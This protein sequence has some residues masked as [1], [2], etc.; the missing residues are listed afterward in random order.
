MWWWYQWSWW[1]SQV[2]PN[3]A[4]CYHNFSYLCSSLRLS[5]ES[6]PDYYRH[7]DNRDDHHADSDR[8]RHN[9]ADDDRRGDYL[10]VSGGGCS[11]NEGALGREGAGEVIGFDSPRDPFAPFSLPEDPVSSKRLSVRSQVGCLALPWQST[12]HL[13]QI[14]SPST[15]AC[16][17]NAANLISFYKGIKLCCSPVNSCSDKITTWWGTCTH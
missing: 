2:G 15:S 17:L 8:D 9:Y 5:L 12:P 16:S 10:G 7:Y 4:H 6:P 3:G 13:F 1:L 14:R 11:D